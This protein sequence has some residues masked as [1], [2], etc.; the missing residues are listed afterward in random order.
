MNSDKI[1]DII[2]AHSL[3]KSHLRKAV[4]LKDSHF[5]VADA[6]NDKKCEFGKWL[7]S[8]EAQRLENHAKLVELHQHFHQQAAQI[9]QLALQGNRHEALAAMELGSCFSKLTSQLVNLL[10]ELHPH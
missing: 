1:K 2:W 3:W 10:N 9:L 7:L 6:G 4:A 8:E 5:S